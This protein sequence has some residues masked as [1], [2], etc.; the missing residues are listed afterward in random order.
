[1]SKDSKTPPI[2]KGYLI[3]AE[4]G[5]I[6]HLTHSNMCPERNNKGSNCKGNWYHDPKCIST[7]KIKHHTIN[8]MYV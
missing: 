6:V 5:N 7:H 2:M 4:C 3:C 8:F 1:M